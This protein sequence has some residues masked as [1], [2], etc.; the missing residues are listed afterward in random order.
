[1]TNSGT[2]RTELERRALRR[3]GAW[4][5]IGLAALAAA[6]LGAPQAGPF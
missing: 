5:L 3:L 4:G 1:M 2:G 6:L